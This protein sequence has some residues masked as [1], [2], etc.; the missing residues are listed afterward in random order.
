MTM[1][2][3]VGRNQRKG[4]LA[5]TKYSGKT[6]V[7]LMKDTTRD[8]PRWFH[9][10]ERG[11]ASQKSLPIRD[12]DKHSDG[13]TW[14]SWCMFSVKPGLVT[15]TDRASGSIRP[16]NSIGHFKDPILIMGSFDRS[17]HHVR[18]LSI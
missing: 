1:G 6:V 18:H 3:A 17:G 7:E 12:I 15:E 2:L 4:Q 9:R 5:E 16:N 11:R 13:L 10:G 8:S 14:S